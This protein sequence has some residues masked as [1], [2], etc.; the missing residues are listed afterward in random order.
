MVI[1]DLWGG[2]CDRIS[3]PTT[4]GASITVIEDFTSEGENYRTIVKIEMLAG[5]NVTEITP[6]FINQV[7]EDREVAWK[8][9]IKTTARINN[10]L[11]T[12]ASF[13]GVDILVG[14]VCDIV[15]NS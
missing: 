6:E 14:L 13:L 12:D 7:E 9:F 5:D 2:G 8:T 3:L 1:I 15:A 11:V 4:P 10:G